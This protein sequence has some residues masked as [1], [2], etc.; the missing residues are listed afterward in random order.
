MFLESA[1]VEESMTGGLL[2]AACYF[3]NQCHICSVFVYRTV[4]LFE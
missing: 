2:G 3:N 4:G 1:R